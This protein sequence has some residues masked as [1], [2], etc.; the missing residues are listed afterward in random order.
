[1]SG[2][3]EA[4]AGDLLQHFRLHP[5]N[6][7]GEED[8]LRLAIIFRQP[9]IELA[10]DVELHVERLAVVHVRFVAAGPGERFAAG[11]DLQA[12]S[13]DA[14]AVKKLRMLFGPV[15]ADDADESDAGEETGGDREVGCG[16]PQ[17]VVAAFDRRFDVI[18]G[19]GTDDKQRHGVAT[20]GSETAGKMKRQL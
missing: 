7:V 12:R 5:G 14:A 20:K 18:N 10:E 11:D 2:D 4:P 8:V 16:A 9:R 13:V 1:M 3:D 15:V 17:H 6:A 19:D